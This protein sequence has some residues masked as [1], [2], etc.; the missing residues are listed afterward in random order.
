LQQKAANSLSFKASRIFDFERVRDLRFS[1][2]KMNDKFNY[3]ISSSSFL[4]LDSN[5]VPLNE[6]STIFVT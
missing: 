2:R 1:A 6:I 3:G 4:L 5:L